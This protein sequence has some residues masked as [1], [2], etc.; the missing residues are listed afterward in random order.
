MCIIENEKVNWNITTER[1]G[2]ADGK[3]E[4]GNSLLLKLYNARRVS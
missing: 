3:L 4:E 1:A 2:V